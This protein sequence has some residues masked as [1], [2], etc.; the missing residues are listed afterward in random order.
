[1]CG[2]NGIFGHS[3]LEEAKVKIRKMN[4]ALAHRG[5]NADGVWGN[6][7]M[8]LGHRRLSIIDLDAGANQPM[9]DATGRYVL[10]FNGEIYNFKDLKL[11][12]R[13]YDFQ[14]QGDT[15][16]LLAGLI[17]WGEKFIQSLNGMFAFAFWDKEKEELLL[18][19]DRFGIKPLYY[20]RTNETLTFSS[21]IRALMSSGLIGKKLNTDRIG[22]YLRYQT[23]HGSDTMIEGVFKLAPASWMKIQDNE[24]ETKAYWDATNDT[25]FGI[26]KLSRPD[27]LDRIQSEFKKAVSR[28]LVADVPM[29]AFLSGGIDSSALVGMAAEL[30]HGKLKTFNIAF[31][32]GEFSEAKYARMVAD[33]F[34]TDH[35][36]IKLSP[37]QLIDDLPDALKAMDHPSGDGIN[38]YVV[39]KAAKNAGISVALSGLGGDE[40]FAGYPIFKQFMSLGDKYWLMTFPKFLRR[41]AAKGLNAIQPGIPSEKKGQI[42]TLDYL[43]IEYVY[44]FSREVATRSQAAA[45]SDVGT[46]GIETVHRMVKGALEFG[47]PG[48]ALPKL[49]KVSYAEI[50]IYLEA[51]LLRDTD[52]MSMAHALEVRVPFLDHEF[53]RTVLSVSDQE[54]YPASPKKLFVDA[55]GD[56]LPSE[57]VNRP[58]MGF[59]FPWAEW[60]NGEL[61]PFCEHHINQ[62]AAR[63]YFNEKAVLHRWK[64]FLNGNKSVT[65]GRIWYLCVLDAWMETNGI[66]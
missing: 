59:T 26:Q 33:R 54:K 62:L 50:Y 38:T 41:L 6:G 8:A 52:Q 29:G 21:E 15:E 53:V 24:I 28:R 5:P 30:S 10:V 47:L 63:P 34:D 46:G 1:M 44:P 37:H 2:I 57:I 45:L 7:P 3:S 13:D 31:D 16:V 23:V 40:L 18:A 35:S 65:W 12:L 64:Q 17:R 39:S 60:M 25:Q 49:S 43:D 14:T 55:M 20:T 4:D 36:E 56:M 42:L 61:R 22:D 27:L 48:F 11:G 66:D 32:E 19:R 51:V 9:V 58:K